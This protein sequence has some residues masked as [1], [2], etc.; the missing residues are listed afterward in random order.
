MFSFAFEAFCSS[1][2]MLD[3]MHCI[4]LIRSKY[5]LGPSGPARHSGELV[6][7]HCKQNKSMAVLLF[8]LPFFLDARLVKANQTMSFLQLETAAAASEARQYYLSRISQR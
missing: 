7:P 6:A 1:C 3:R 2:N 5:V 8:R 4:A